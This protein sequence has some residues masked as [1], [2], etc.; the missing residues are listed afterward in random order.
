MIEKISDRKSKFGIQAIDKICHRCLGD[1]INIGSDGHPYCDDCYE[2]VLISD[3]LFLERY[4]RKRVRK[5]HQ[6]N[7]NID[8][9]KDQLKGQTFVESCYEN[10]N[11]GFLHAVCGAGKTEMCLSTILKALLDNK[12]MA[13]IIPR[14]EIIK[15][16]VKRLKNY[17]PK[18][19]IC[20]LF[21]G[22]TLDDQADLYISTPQ[23]M[24]KFYH[25][26][27]LIFI[28]EVD[29]FPFYNNLFLNRLV[30]KAIKAKG[31]KIYIS[32]T[33]PKEYLDMI[34]DKQFVYCLITSRFHGKDLIVPI[35]KKYESIWS[36][37]LIK[38]IQ[39]YLSGKDR[40][41]IY[42]PSIQ[43]MEVFHT[44]LNKKGI[45][46]KTL[47]SK[48]KYRHSILKEFSKVEFKILLST[49]LLERGV[50]F[51][52]CDVFVLEADH[53]VYS[54]DTLIQ[55]SGRVGRDIIYTGGLLVFYSRYI[56]NEMRLSRQ[57][58]KYLNKEK[59]NDL[60]SL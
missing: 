48:T 29:A 34:N 1:N 25:E 53:P 60:S 14:V 54:K 41:I 17:L 43:L 28:D 52:R 44:H 46:N 11:N 3:Y 32:A 49:T 42:F 19:N 7:I 30:D 50:T 21:E 15:Q 47:S 4:F 23:Q 40:L 33:M 39:K 38:D 16:L 59:N 22:T 20:P 10:N 58:L 26:F 45:K 27:D 2:S 5:N 24:I 57:E 9:S 35:F 31:I 18:T 37:R 13:F 8:L 51:S 12:S 36:H 6:L 56:S 55:I